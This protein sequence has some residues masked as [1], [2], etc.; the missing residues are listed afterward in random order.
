MLPM[1]VCVPPVLNAFQLCLLTYPRRQQGHGSALARTSDTCTERSGDRLGSEYVARD[2]AVAYFA[3]SFSHV[4]VIGTS[5]S[6]KLSLHFMLTQ[7]SAVT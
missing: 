7:R 5:I 3:G 1:T 4:R 2:R 6:A